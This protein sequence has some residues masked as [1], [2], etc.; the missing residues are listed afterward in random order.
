MHQIKTLKDSFIPPER[1]I[2]CHYP[3]YFKRLQKERQL[4]VKE[5]ICMK[6]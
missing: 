6:N 3:G 5:K 4:Q 1:W 2:P